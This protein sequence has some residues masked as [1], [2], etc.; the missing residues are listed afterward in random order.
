MG[1]NYLLIGHF[2]GLDKKKCLVRRESRC[3]RAKRTT[4]KEG[5]MR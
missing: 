1:I 3:E 2:D 5:K 4:A